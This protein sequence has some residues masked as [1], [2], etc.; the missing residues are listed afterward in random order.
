MKKMKLVFSFLEKVYWFGF[1]VTVFAAIFIFLIFVQWGSIIEKQTGIEG[2]FFKAISEYAVKNN[3]PIVQF[4]FSPAGFSVLALE[5]V[6]MILLAYLHAKTFTQLHRFI[7]AK[8][9]GLSLS[10][11]RKLLRPIPKYI[12]AAYCFDFILALSKVPK[13]GTP[14]KDNVPE[15]MRSMSAVTDVAFPKLLPSLG[16]P[17]G[18]ILALLIYFYCQSLAQTESLSEETQKLRDEADLII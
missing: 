6:S 5:I 14:N 4:V 18:L 9:S 17:L 1:A 7:K 12:V 8:I 11:Q 3:D 2:D 13:Y 15:W 16:T 10:D